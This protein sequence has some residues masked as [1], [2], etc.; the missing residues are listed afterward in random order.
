MITLFRDFAELMLS[1]GLYFTKLL[2]K[3]SIEM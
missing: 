2:D 3:I 1:G